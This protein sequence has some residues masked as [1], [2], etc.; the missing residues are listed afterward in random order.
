MS[1]ALSLSPHRIRPCVVLDLETTGYSPAKGARIIEL[2]AVT[3]TAD[4]QVVDRRGVLVHQPR[5]TLETPSA[6]RAREQSHHIST[7]EVLAKGIPEA[8]AAHRFCTYLERMAE[9]HT[10]DGVVV[11]RAWNQRFEELFLAQ[12]LWTDALQHIQ[13]GVE[14]GEDC[15]KTAKNW[16]KNERRFTH[17]QGKKIGGSIKLERLADFLGVTYSNHRAAADAQLTA[18]VLVAIEQW[19]AQE[20][21][22]RA[23][24][25][26]E[27]RN[28][29]ACERR[30]A[31]AL[32]AAKKRR[33]KKAPRLEP[34]ERLVLRVRTEE[35]RI[36][37]RRVTRR[38]GELDGLAHRVAERARTVA[39]DCR[40][41]AQHLP[42]NWG[43]K[44]IRVVEVL[45]RQEVMALAP[46]DVSVPSLFGEDELELLAAR[47]A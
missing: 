24:M 11:L 43:G 7:A 25:T 15:M 40:G 44:T 22:R 34:E 3:L 8:E 16:L 37:E 30:N 45:D 27:E 31:A 26:P 6:I 41:L 18:E 10:D 33:S 32:A 13:C 42:I 5:H 28:R 2:G 21:A 14:W 20:R 29:R 4:L 1:T 9:Q 23:R 12:P 46:A 35:G 17:L 47:A 19:R 36:L 38:P 39:A